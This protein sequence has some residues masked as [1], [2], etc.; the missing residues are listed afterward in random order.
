M[1]ATGKISEQFPWLE[2]KSSDF[3][4]ELL[5]NPSSRKAEE[6]ECDRCHR[7]TRTGVSVLGPWNSMDLQGKNEFPCASAH[8]VTTAALLVLDPTL[9]MVWELLQPHSERLHVLQDVPKGRS[10]EKQEQDS[11]LPFNSSF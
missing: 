4:L 11:P 10:K 7:K 6:T 9:D 8:S 5:I 1:L 3:V 2:P